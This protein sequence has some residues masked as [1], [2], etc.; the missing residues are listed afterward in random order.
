MFSYNALKNITSLLCE[1]IGYVQN[2]FRDPFKTAY[3]A[4]HAIGASKFDLTKGTVKP[5]LPYQND[6]HGRITNTM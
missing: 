2:V 1:L 3:V 5:S 4:L 6:S